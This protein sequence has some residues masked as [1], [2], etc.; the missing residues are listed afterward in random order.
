MRINQKKAGEIDL[1]ADTV[2]IS[3]GLRSQRAL[4]DELK[5][6]FGENAYLVGDAE[7]P[8]NILIAVQK[9]NEVAKAI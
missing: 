2:I 9:A 7:A 8:G 5:E 4:Y 3:I 6:S 1:P